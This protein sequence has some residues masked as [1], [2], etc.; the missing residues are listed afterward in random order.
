MNCEILTFQ[1]A[2]NYGALLQCY[3]LKKYIESI[4]LN[5]SVSRFTPD[6]VK[7]VY[8]LW[9]ELQIKHP[10]YFVKELFRSFRRIKQYKIFESFISDELKPGDLPNPDYLIIGSD[11]VWNESI[12]GNI[13]DYYGS[14]YKN[15]IKIA[16]AG[17]FGTS[18]LTDF[19]KQNIVK[20]FPKFEK[21]SLRES[22]NIP[23]V[24]NLINQDV[25]CVL[26]PVFLLSKEEWIDLEKSP[27]LKGNE[28]Y[29]LYY[30]LMYDEALVNKITQ[31]SCE[32]K[33][34]VI[35]IHPT[36][37][38]SKSHFAQLNDVGP[39]EFIYL[40]RNALLVGTNSFHAVAFSQ[41]FGK[42]VIYKS[43]SKNES[44]VPT[45]LNYCGMD[46]DKNTAKMY[47]FSIC[48]TSLI[49]SKKIESQNFL[50]DALDQKD[51]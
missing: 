17:S 9:P 10:K 29:I 21:I 22:C 44:R 46:Y 32:L 7:N 25:E 36:C 16:Y 34:K 28:K 35:A 18:V 38:K 3:A 51:E 39:K 45:I 8:R 26:D 47:D 1:F 14:G 2:H 6:C 33:C 50:K 11:Q 41:I 27:N 12:T 13:T 5:T 42:K 30:S 43:Y 40:I 23:E 48:D 15:A 4:D 20:Y 19:Q 31:L 24:K 49:E 37:V